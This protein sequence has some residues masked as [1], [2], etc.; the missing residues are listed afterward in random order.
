MWP[1]LD[2]FNVDI[3]QKLKLMID[4]MKRTSKNPTFYAFIKELEQQLSILRILMQD[5][6]QQVLFYTIHN[7]FTTK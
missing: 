6:K 5:T 4:T 1:V 7:A 3:Q 2:L